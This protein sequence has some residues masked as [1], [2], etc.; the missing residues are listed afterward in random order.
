M[1][2]IALTIEH[3][4][5]YRALM[6]QAYTL[7]P[8][9]FTSTAQE[10][11]ALP[12]SWWARRL[13]TGPAAESQAFGVTQGGV[14]VGAVALT[15][16]TQPK[17]R[18]KSTLVGMYVRESSQHQGVGSCLVQAVLAAAHQRSGVRLVQLTVSETNP[19]A[20]RLYERN[21]FVP[22]GVEPFAMLGTEGYVAKCHMWCSLSATPASEK[23]KMPQ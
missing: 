16:A 14:L 7:H 17:T 4:A 15:Y 22:F 18:H 23:S 1:K 12:E 13:E 19:R 5:D 2:A 10:R 8:N 3:L 9:A 21:G 20:K 11:A 6:L